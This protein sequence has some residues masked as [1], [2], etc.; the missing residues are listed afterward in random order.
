MVGYINIGK[1]PKL[2]QNRTMGEFQTPN[3][4][5]MKALTENSTISVL[6]PLAEVFVPQFLMGEPNGERNDGLKG[7]TNESHPT[8]ETWL[9]GAVE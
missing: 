2:W 6:S 1:V 9:P 3:H 4:Q 8:A 5:K 7:S